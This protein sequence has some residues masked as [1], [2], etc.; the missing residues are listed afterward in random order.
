MGDRDYVRLAH[1]I[2]PQ[3]GAKQCGRS[4]QGKLGVRGQ[5]KDLGNNAHCAAQRQALR[6][7]LI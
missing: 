6:S 4:W 3:C 2:S 7:S 5:K 1:G